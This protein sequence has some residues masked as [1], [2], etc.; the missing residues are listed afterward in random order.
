MKRVASLIAISVSAFLVGLGVMASLGSSASATSYPSGWFKIYG[1][2]TSC[3]L[4]QATVND[5]TNKAGTV[6]ENRYGCSHSNAYR[7]VPVGYLFARVKLRD[8][9]TDYICGDSDLKY[10]TTVDASITTTA[11]WIEGPGC[12]TGQLYRGESVN[13]RDTDTEGLQSIS[14]L[15]PSAVF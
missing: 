4:A 14:L 7:N 11:A 12:R 8:R 9:T 13:Y 6:T 2:S 10:N 1:H 3:A 15:S 5:S